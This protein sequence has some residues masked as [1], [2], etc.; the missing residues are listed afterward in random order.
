[1]QCKIDLSKNIVLADNGVPSK[2]YKDL[3]SRGFSK[4]QAI[5]VYNNSL[6]K[7]DRDNLIVDENNEPLLNTNDLTFTSKNGY[8]VNAINDSNSFT[9]PIPRNMNPNLV[10][11][12][13]PDTVKQSEHHPSLY[14]GNTIAT[15]S[16]KKLFSKPESISPAILKLF[17]PISDQEDISVIITDDLYTYNTYGYTKN[18]GSYLP[19]SRNTGESIIYIKA[20][21]TKDGVKLDEGIILHEYLHALTRKKIDSNPEFKSKIT[22]IL[23]YAQNVALERDFK[24]YGLYDEYELIAVTFNDPS[25]RKFLSTIPSL[26][27]STNINL[28]QEIVELI[29]N[30]LG[31]TNKT[32]L[33]DVFEVTSEIITSDNIVTSPDMSPSSAVESITMIR[34]NQVLDAYRFVS[35]NIDESNVI[36]YMSSTVSNDL[37]PIFDKIKTNYNSKIII[38]KSSDLK[39]SK[40]IGNIET[41]DVTDK[42]RRQLDPDRT[43]IV[44]DLYEIAL[45]ADSKKISYENALAF[46]FIHEVAHEKLSNLNYKDYETLRNIY[47]QFV[48]YVKE[49]DVR[50]R[51]IADELHSLSFDEF[52]ANSVADPSFRDILDSIQREDKSLL[53]RIIEFILKIL[54]LKPNRSLETIYK[55]YLENSITHQSGENYSLMKY[56]FRSSSAGM[57]EKPVPA[58]VQKRMV[59]LTRNEIIRKIS[60]AGAAISEGSTESLS[61]A[62]FNIKEV[63]KAVL[64]RESDKYTPGSLVSR[65][66]TEGRDKYISNIDLFN[67]YAAMYAPTNDKIDQISEEVKESLSQLYGLES[68]FFDALDSEASEEETS[69]EDWIQDLAPY[70]K[71]GIDHVDNLLRVYLTTVEYTYFDQDLQMQIENEP[72]DVA[73]V[74]SLLVRNFSEKPLGFSNIFIQQ[75]FFNS[76]AEMAK[77]SPM[78]N[79]LYVDLLSKQETDSNIINLFIKNLNKN[80]ISHRVI[81]F[82]PVSK[83]FDNIQS[84]RYDVVGIQIRD[85]SYNWLSNNMESQ[86]LKSKDARK[87]FE[88]DMSQVSSIITNAKNASNITEY[89]SQN[90]E[91]ISKI[92]NNY[93]GIDL[94]PKYIKHSLIDSYLSDKTTPSTPEEIQLFSSHK[95]Y[96]VNQNEWLTSEFIEAV[97]MSIIKQYDRPNIILYRGEE[98][99]EESGEITSITTRIANIAEGNAIFDE[100]IITPSFKNARNQLMYSYQEPSLSSSMPLFLREENARRAMRGDTVSEYQSLQNEFNKDN[101]LLHFD[102]VIEGSIYS[103]MSAIV[104]MN[105]RVRPKRMRGENPIEFEKRRKAMTGQLGVDH[106]TNDLRTLEVN[107][108]NYF[109]SDKS[110]VVTWDP[111]SQKQV[112]IPRRVMFLRQYESKSTNYAVNLPKG[113]PVRQGDEIVILPVVKG[114][115]PTSEAIEMM[116][117]QFEAEVNRINRASKELKNSLPELLKYLNGQDNNYQ[118]DLLD[119]YHVNIG[120][121]EDPAISDA[122]KRNVYRKMII[123]GI[124]TAF[125]LSKFKNTVTSPALLEQLNALKSQIQKL[126]NGQDVELPTIELNASIKKQ[127][128]DSIKADIENEISRYTQHLKDLEILK[129]NN[130]TNQ[131]ELL[132]GTSQIGQYTNGRTLYSEYNDPAAFIADFVT[133]SYI[134]TMLYNNL[135]DG[136]PAYRSGG[137]FMQIVKRASGNNA[138]GPTMYYG[139]IRISIIQEPFT[140]EGKN[141]RADG[142]GY[143][144]ANS[145]FDKS[146]YTLGR[147]YPKVRKIL[148]SIKL[149][150]PVSR[151]NIKYLESTNTLL[152]SKKDVYFLREDYNKDSIVPLSLEFTSILPKENEQK[153]NEIRD[154]ILELENDSYWNMPEGSNK[155]QLAATINRLYK[156]LEELYV[157]DPTREILH[158]IRRN[159]VLGDI[160][161]VLPPSAVKLKKPVPAR[162]DINTNNY[163]FSKSTYQ[164]DGRFWRLQQETPSGKSTITYFTQALQLIDNEQLDDSVKTLYPING[165]I[166][167][168]GELKQIYRKMLG[169]IRSNSLKEAMDLIGRMSDTGDEFIPTEDMNV[170]REIISESLINSGADNNLIEIFKD[171]SFNLNMPNTINKLENLFYSYFSKGVLAQKSPGSK[172]TIISDWGFNL[173]R[174]SSGKVI[175]SNVYRDNIDTYFDNVNGKLVL[176]PGYTMSRL[177]PPKVKEDGSLT[178]AEAVRPPWDN[179]TTYTKFSKLPK[180]ILRGFG[181]R[182]P[183]DDKHSMVAFELQDFLPSFMGDVI[184]LPSEVVDLQGADFDVDALYYIRKDYFEYRDNN[185]KFQIK[186]YDDHTNLKDEFLSYITYQQKHNP[187]VKV[188]VEDMKDDG[189]RKKDGLTY[190][191]ALARRKELLT[192]R[193]KEIQKTDAELNNL[194]DEIRATFEEDI[195]PRLQWIKAAR[196][197]IGV[198]YSELNRLYDT[199][200][201]HYHEVRPEGVKLIQE[202]QQGIEEVKEDVSDFYELVEGIKQEIKT[203][204]KGLSEA[205]SSLN[206]EIKQMNTIID[207][208]EKSMVVSALQKLSLP[209]NIKTMK[210]VKNANPNFN[211]G[212]LQNQ[213]VDININFLVNKNN[214]DIYFYPTSMIRTGVGGNKYLEL[215]SGQEVELTN[216]RDVARWIQGV[217]VTNYKHDSPYGQA[218]A[219]EINQTGASIIG[220]VAFMN[221]VNSVFSKVNLSDR[222]GALT[223]F[224]VPVPVVKDTTTNI[225]KQELEKLTVKQL[226][227]QF[228]PATI[229]DEI[230]IFFAE[231]GRIKPENYK[232]W[233]DKN[234]LTK[235]ISLNFTSKNGSNINVLANNIAESFSQDEQSVI[236]RIISFINSNDSPKQYIIDRILT[237]QQYEEIN[238]T[239]YYSPVTFNKFGEVY[240]NDLIINK[241]EDGFTIGDGSYKFRIND[242]IATMLQEGVDNT[243]HNGSYEF[244]LTDDNIGAYMTGVSLKLGLNRVLFGIA[245]S[246]VLGVYN[247]MQYKSKYNIKTDSDSMLNPISFLKDSTINIANTIV[248]ILTEQGND[249]FIN[250]MLL[251]N[252]EVVSSVDDILSLY[253][254]NVFDKDILWA[255]RIDSSGEMTTLTEGKIKTF[256]ELIEFYKNDTG[257]E[258]AGL[259]SKL[260]V[261]NKVKLLTLMLGQHNTIKNFSALKNLSDKVRAT[262]TILGINKGIAATTADNWRKFDD[263][264]ET[265]DLQVIDTVLIENVVSVEDPT[266]FK[267]DA[268]VGDYALFEGEV[269]GRKVL[270]RKRGNKAVIHVIPSDNQMTRMQA[271][272]IPYISVINAL[273]PDIVDEILN[274]HTIVHVVAP[275][276]I[277]LANEIFKSVKLEASI[278][279]A[280]SSRAKDFLNESTIQSF[281]HMLIT[282]YVQENS[283]INLDP[284]QLYHYLNFQETVKDDGTVTFESADDFKSVTIVSKIEDVI[285]SYSTTLNS[286]NSFLDKDYTSLFAAIRDLNKLID[287]ETNQERK[288]RLIS[289]R[290]IADRH[291][292]KETLRSNLFFRSS[293]IAKPRGLTNITEID[294][295]R[296]NTFTKLTADFSQGLIN[297]ME[298]LYYHPDEDI[299][300]IALDLYNLL[301]LKDGLL[302]KSGSYLKFLPTD[303]LRPLSSSIDNLQQKIEA[304]EPIGGKTIFE[305]MDEFQNMY[306][307]IGD[308]P[309]FIPQVNMSIKNDSGQ[310]VRLDQLIYEHSG[311]I[312]RSSNLIKEDKIKTING[313]SYNGN[314]PN[315]NGF[316]Y[317]T[318][319]SNLHPE[320]VQ[321][322]QNIKKFPYLDGEEQSEVLYK[323]LWVFE[324]LTS[325]IPDKINEFVAEVKKDLYNSD[326]NTVLLD[327]NLSKID[328]YN[329]LMK[330]L[331]SAEKN[332]ERSVIKY[333]SIMD[334][335]SSGTKVNIHNVINS[336]IGKYTNF[337]TFFEKTVTYD[338]ETGERIDATSY[339]TYKLVRLHR[340][341]DGD[342]RSALYSKVLPINHQMY[343][344]LNDIKGNYQI[345]MDLTQALGKGRYRTH[346]GK[347]ETDEQGNPK[348]RPAYQNVYAAS[349]D[350]LRDLEIFTEPQNLLDFDVIID[351]PINIQNMNAELALG[352]RKHDDQYKVIY[353]NKLESV[354]DHYE[355]V[356]SD[357]DSKENIKKLTDILK[358]L[359]SQHNLIPVINS[360]G[361]L[362][363]VLGLQASTPLEE[364]NG[365][366]TE[367]LY[368]RALANAYYTLTKN[369]TQFIDSKINPV[370]G[371]STGSPGAPEIDNDPNV[372]NEEIAKQAALKQVLDTYTGHSGGARSGDTYWDLIG[373]EYGFMKFNHWREPGA[374]KLDSNE[375]KDVHPKLMTPADYA[376]G[377]AKMTRVAD[378]LGR[379]ISAKSAHYQYR[380]WAQVKYSDAIFAIAPILEKGEADSKGYIASV[381]QVSGGTAYAV[382]AAILEGKPVYVFDENKEKWFTWQNKDF[383]ETDVPVLTKNFAAIGSREVGQKGKDAIRAVYL[384]TLNSLQEGEKPKGDINVSYLKQAEVIQNDV[385]KF[386]KSHYPQLSNF[387]TTYKQNIKDEYGLV[388][389]YVENY[390]QAQKFLDKQLREQF[391]NVTPVQAKYLGGSKGIG[392]KYVRSDW[393]YRVKYDV[394]FK[395]LK[396]KFSIPYY[397]DI[398]ASTGNKQIIEWTTWNDVIWGMSANTGKGANALGKL[399]MMV[400]DEVELTK[401]KSVA[402]QLSLFDMTTENIK[403]AIQSV[404]PNL[405]A[406]NFSNSDTRPMRQDLLQDGIDNTWDAIKAGRRTATSRQQKYLPKVG[407]LLPFSKKGKDTYLLTKVVKV[408]SISL[409]Q[410]IDNNKG[411]DL[412]KITKPSDLSQ[413]RNPVLVFG[414]NT[415]GRHGLGTAKVAVEQFG[416]EYNNAQGMQGNAYAIITKDLAKGERSIP[417]KYIKEQIAKLYT[418]ALANPDR[419]YIIPYKW[420]SKNLNGYSSK[421]M[422]TVFSE[423]NIIP[424]NVIFEKEFGTKVYQLHWSYTQGWSPNYLKLNPDTLD[425]YDVFTK[426]IGEVDSDG[427]F[428]DRKTEDHPDTEC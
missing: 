149:G 137:D 229:E 80:S 226:I 400:R 157:A 393:D 427:N 209:H 334:S 134:Y 164:L 1:M 239:S 314:M 233:G 296:I 73:S 33:D 344:Y 369:T 196:K 280:N 201:E 407:E 190:R 19:I 112:R 165:K 65:M 147:S 414:S 378:I 77:D 323:L 319:L 302:F 315:N 247:K 263:S 74:Y 195:I 97:K 287:Q 8:R 230:A 11:F 405:S 57:I 87:S 237:D 69:V 36:D 75:E 304:K 410:K 228:T 151:K 40:F 371:G 238:S 221:I 81:L 252:E 359:I 189:R 206:K 117:T 249:V 174:D 181:T 222:T 132:A 330:T 379:K 101:P 85:W 150:L 316:M 345:M 144:S 173:L 404:D 93:L 285:K 325:E 35:Q 53:D 395:A 305:V 370:T 248:G 155:Q 326:K 394:M 95:F 105:T 402:E 268:D 254:N 255:A 406:T 37:K 124:G 160:D 232:E 66:G 246:P 118:G 278:T 317:I 213:L 224:V 348:F 10:I 26:D 367:S 135:T 250:P 200:T 399:L 99:K 339:N 277:L 6:V 257:L 318:P 353:G 389:P 265:L 203:E 258:L 212:S 133:N 417:L 428:V 120:Y 234:T 391:V 423:H 418:L 50:S 126:I 288:E 383:V 179:Y 216:I 374:K 107:R 396:V 193:A 273:T 271:A 16:V 231:G 240:E 18:A 350:G 47:N 307:L 92:L 342:V 415:Q 340:D 88:K 188:L 310:F 54:G 272:S 44:L 211:N 420:E 175:P 51:Y 372:N 343:P 388:Y 244:G 191:Q 313:M 156:D 355:S 219:F 177:Q 113:I 72:I 274:Y 306:M 256:E 364:L 333:N 294:T 346:Q 270:F 25:F 223:E 38:D 303:I 425:K 198:I 373:R 409:K 106:K 43:N 166:Y 416:A 24:S 192:Q 298:E 421:E 184:I 64:S 110:D 390:Y 259:L 162:L 31:I 49:N 293:K 13:L 62:D 130:I 3:L 71:G 122:V 94:S 241:T 39:G 332:Y 78:V 68:E 141:N 380:N 207:Q 341:D 91:V 375:L 79:A 82:D 108:I 125:D 331:A 210:E 152:N 136:D 352:L 205:L 327:Y 168:V 84:N 322:T 131:Y 301:L 116:Y 153:A 52:V 361:G 161:I 262:G 58:T 347:V 34:Q 354:Y 142:Q 17:E 14:T 148:Q 48:Q 5:Q 253:N 56:K 283:N 170:F 329:E 199:N 59:Y 4:E 169:D 180:A 63:A 368:V 114:T 236:E 183:T 413:Y 139:D 356:K 398:L 403:Q 32:L 411:W 218:N 297:A 215:N 362:D 45:L 159:M 366:G 324:K 55:H 419:D 281:F 320:F 401:P 96:N 145:L 227:K 197:D 289:I 392:K 146:Y 129:H 312:V 90:V 360:N 387:D 202:G 21:K 260:P 242:S 20:L 299:R 397:K 208:L 41:A 194:Y 328:F 163:D 308:N 115:E 337:V 12:E 336:K 275:K 89:I 154:R 225:T 46:A 22:E 338:E 276:F 29:K 321:L 351:Q 70:N 309:S 382:H 290:D 171:P 424:D 7:R 349:E 245:K 286:I 104:S 422:A 204:K 42:V 2:L 140:E 235:N 284:K 426:Y 9:T 176:K 76:L 123:R 279:S 363:Y 358:A 187:K 28:F 412:D 111:V 103:D 60:E 127:A 182:I 83:Q 102:P 266:L 311:G 357:E 292:N 109:L 138:A 121:A 167:T 67:K 381:K 376:E 408:D 300:Q 61:L 143:I 217:N 282:N 158:N 386:D 243:K 264:L 23:N 15:T 172:V 267:A 86:L 214:K 291:K 27:P 100:R 128:S 365:K 178:L 186:L 269:K 261:E 220:P 377:K 185:G 384:K 385:I 30:A 98:E 251:P 335:K 119:A 295:I